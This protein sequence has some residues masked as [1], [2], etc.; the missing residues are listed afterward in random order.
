MEK[1]EFNVHTEICD[2]D[3]LMSEYASLHGLDYAQ[4]TLI[5][6]DGTIYGLYR[7]GCDYGEISVPCSELIDE[8]DNAIGIT[9]LDFG[10]YEVAFAD[11]AC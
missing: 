3:M 11:E 9:Y 7:V 1:M 2:A 8:W 6:A 5:E 10:K 4:M